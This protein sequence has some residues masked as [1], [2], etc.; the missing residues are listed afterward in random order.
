[1]T[2]MRQHRLVVAAS[3]ALLCTPF[4][5]AQFED[6][7][8]A[9]AIVDD[10]ELPDANG[11]Q[12]I[13]VLLDG[14]ASTA[15]LLA[16]AGVGLVEE[17]ESKGIL[18]VRP[19][20]LST[21]PG[22]LRS[23]LQ[24]LRSHPDVA[25][26]EYNRRVVPPETACD[27]PFQAGVQQC[28]IGVVDG[29]PTPGEY[30]GQPAMS[31]IEAEAAGN[32]SLGFTSVVAVIDTG[33]DPTH[34]LFNGR[35]ASI[36]FDFI[37]DRRGGFDLPNGIDDDGDG[38]VDE[39]YGHGTHVAGTVLLINRDALVLPIRA[40]DADGRGTAFDVA[41]AIFYAVESGA[42]VINLSLS[43]NGPSLAIGSAL[44]YAQTWGA[45]VFSSAGNTGANHVMFPAN[46]DPNDV[47][48]LNLPFIPPK[49]P[50]IGLPIY[51][52]AAVDASDVLASFSAYGTDVDFCAPGVDIYSAVPGGAYARWS[53][54]SMACAVASGAA[55]LLYSSWTK[56][57]PLVLA[58]G[59]IL[60]A[61]ADPIGS[62]NPG[63]EG[64]LGTGRI[65]THAAVVTLTN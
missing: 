17:I 60:M 25:F 9:P 31:S 62:V 38:D 5:H 34:P 40:M 41:Q 37:D 11:T 33:I 54:T 10:G 15:G 24:T 46:Y 3:L 19:L 1:M 22:Y 42:D 43:M 32:L 44:L 65:N 6:P 23:I 12:D 59:Q 58:A 45:R 64:L 49:L 29:D 14:G 2:E 30:Y 47:I 57:I 7:E 28:T 35:T 21:A 48:D 53:G 27:L 36:G 26:A 20:D 13:I 61:T 8:T 16:S 52:V 50:A 55:S 4:A 18:R 39:A 51:A 63:F 56:P